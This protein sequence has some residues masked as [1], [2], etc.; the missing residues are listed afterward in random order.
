LICNIFI[1]VR[2]NKAAS[3]AASATRWAKFPQGMSANS[4]AQILW[5][6]VCETIPLIG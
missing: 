2:K 1:A 3:F 6:K 5:I 4:F